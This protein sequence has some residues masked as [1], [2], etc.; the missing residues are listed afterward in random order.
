MEFK[1]SRIKNISLIFIAALVLA[2]CGGAPSGAGGGSQLVSE[3]EITLG[4]ANIVADGESSL[5][6]RAEV[7]DQDGNAIFG[8]TV[9]FESTL[10]SL[11]TTA[12]T[13]DVNGIA[14]V[15]L[16]AGN[17]AG[18]ATVTVSASGF[19]AS[20]IVTFS[21]ADGGGVIV[22]G[23][24]L[25]S[26]IEV[27]LGGSSI[28]ANSS[29]TVAVRATIADQDGDAISGAIVEFESDL[30]SLSAATAVTNA[31]GIAQVI[32][33]AGSVA[34]SSAVRVSASGFNASST[35]AFLS[36]GADPG[37]QLVSSIVITLG[38]SSV[39]ANG[40][41]T[42]AVRATVADQNGDA[43]SG[44]TVAFESS[45]GSLSSAT[46][47]TDDNGI[48]QVTLTAGLVPGA[49]SIEASAS[50]FNASGTVTFI[51]TGTPDLIVGGVVLT[52][53]SDTVVAGGGDIAVRATV[54]DQNGGLLGGAVVGFTSTSGT[55]ASASATTGETGIAE[56]LLTPGALTG[57]SLITVAASGFSDSG[58]VTLIPGS[59]VSVDLRFS[60]ASVVTSGTSVMT[61]TVVD[62]NGNVVSGETVTFTFDTEGSG[63]PVLSLVTAL[64]N[65][66]GVATSTYTAGSSGGTDTLTARTSNNSN[67]ASSVVVSAEAVIVGSIALTLGGESVV[68]DGAT[69]V[70]IRAE[71]LDVDSNPVVGEIVSFSSSVGS[72]SAATDTTDDDGLAQV[73]LTPGVSPALAL[74]SVNISGFSDSVS[75]PFVAGPPS[76]A[77]SVITGS[78]SSVPADGASTSEVTVLLVD[79]NSNLVADGTS[80][81]LQASAG[82]ITTATTTTT[83]S[84]RANFT[85]QASSISETATLSITQYPGIAG[86]VVFG[87]TGTGTATSVSTTIEQNFLSIAGV[88]GVDNTSITISVT[89][90][91]GALVSDPA[92]DN[93]RIS[94]LTNP[95]GGEFI[96]VGG[97]SNITTIDARTEDG[98][99][100][101]NL[102]AGN[103]PGAVELQ[104]LVDSTGV[105]GS[106]EVTSLIPQISIASGPPETIVLSTPITNSIE[107]IGFGAY[108]RSGTL[109][110]TDRF[111]N[112]VPD[113]TA[114]N[115]GIIDSVIVDSNSGQLTGTSLTD[116]APTFS[117]GSVIAAFNSASIVR[118]SS[119]RFV[120]LGDRVLVTDVI[121]AVDKSRF[122]DSAINL[123][124]VGV[125]SAFDGSET[126][127]DYVIGAALLGA[128][129]SGIDSGGTLTSGSVLTENGLANI[130]VTYPANINTI[131]IGCFEVQDDLRYS[132]N[133]SARVFMVASATSGSATL[134][135]EG[136]LCFAPISGFTLTSNK[137]TIDSTDSVTLRLRDG[138]DR[139]SVV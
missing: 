3:I 54:R 41:D 24:Q 125:Q 50:G 29:D 74:V 118:N 42:L 119:N 128:E 111:G 17:T 92:N 39:T 72:L 36:N 98:S 35:I 61:A 82:S 112:A 100:T 4:A 10:G 131:R 104:I 11:S 68:A 123:T 120:E 28:I 18:A 88:G 130:R 2:A 138:G 126:G 133:D 51:S 37:G 107:N 14:Q 102:Q 1:L 59:A 8:E 30:G 76:A 110:V 75:L 83:S 96:S 94:F 43:I 101:F 132:P 15:A 90:D 73:T 31:G 89:D 13:T 79:A 20:E 87:A 134:V 81:T 69:G 34:G 55:L 53:G 135:D 93:I 85:L 139:K 77:S 40:S 32:L 71:V 52:L 63:I 91:S 62:A 137:D 109:I 25:V 23:D 115:L 64:T 38:A 22:V 60:P 108:R 46:F 70:A 97:A 16:V 47:V 95:G 26:S 105:F 45:L 21:S 99:V 5:A 129:I 86:S 66:N 80:V 124:D 19:N 122:I 6:V 48:A 114:I 65:G 127:L 49:S 84:G 56:V 106:P 116:L 103:L 58:S 7:K 67:D 12:A 33:T 57:A 136:T 121:D 44:E 78:P 9:T 117:D 113:G 27:T